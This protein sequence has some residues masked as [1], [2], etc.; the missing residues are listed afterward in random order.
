MEN[1]KEEKREL[2]KIISS[3]GDIKKHL[4][5]DNVA[6]EQYNQMEKLL[7]KRWNTLYKQTDKNAV[8]ILD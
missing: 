8:S 7:L 3:L 4:S 6:L 2:E 1:I 5:N